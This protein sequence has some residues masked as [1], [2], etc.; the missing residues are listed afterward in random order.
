METF[1]P[2]QRDGD[3]D[4]VE[5]LHDGAG[6][7]QSG[8]RRLDR[9]LHLPSLRPSIINLSN[10]PSLQSTTTAKMGSIA[11]EQQQTTKP[12]FPAEANTL[13]YAQ[14]LDAK[15]HMRSFREKYIIPSK[16]NIKAKKLSKPGDSQLPRASCDCH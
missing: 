15:D 14:S 8:W 12:S 1:G 7:V 16:T 10:N 9:I 6:Q 2:I 3:F 4:A 5:E 11:I 13:E